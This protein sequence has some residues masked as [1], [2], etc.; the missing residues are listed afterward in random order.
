M[1]L[2]VKADSPARSAEK[3]SLDCGALKASLNMVRSLELCPNSLNLNL[4]DGIF[5]HEEANDTGLR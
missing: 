4:R 3:E 5:R 1:K 2:C